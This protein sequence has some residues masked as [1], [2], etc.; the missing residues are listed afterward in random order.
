M[1]SADKTLLNKIFEKT[2]QRLNFILSYYQRKKNLLQ[3]EDP[4]YKQHSIIILLTL[5]EIENI[6]EQLQKKYIIIPQYNLKLKEVYSIKFGYYYESSEFLNNIINDEEELRKLINCSEICEDLNVSVID[7]VIFLDEEE[8]NL[9]PIIE[10]AYNSNLHNLYINYIKK[11]I[12][13]KANEI[14]I[15]SREVLDD[16]TMVKYITQILIFI[17]L[18][19]KY[20]SSMIESLA[21]IDKKKKDAFGED[22]IIT[23]FSLLEVNKSNKKIDSDLLKED[24]LKALNELN[25]FYPLLLNIINQIETIIN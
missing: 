11:F 13:L 24:N 7:D 8:D 23:Y 17:K 12:N 1:K 3:K 10:N 18:Y 19:I 9:Y 25:N 4:Y 16:L 22:A 5:R 15:Y 21:D 6:K 20:G 2:E 14:N